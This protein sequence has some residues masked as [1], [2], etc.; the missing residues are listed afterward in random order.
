MSDWQVLYDKLVVKRHAPDT[1]IAGTDMVVPDAAKQEKNRGTVIACGAGRIAI[2]GSVNPLTIRAGMEVVF[3]KFAG[4]E[5]EDGN[6][7][8]I[9][10]RED[11]ILAYRWPEKKTEEAA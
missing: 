6:P 10:L 5:L 4:T 11:E 7:E 8:V 3:S 9:V 2:T 1:M